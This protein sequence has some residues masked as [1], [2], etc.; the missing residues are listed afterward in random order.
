[1][2]RTMAVLITLFVGVASALAITP[3]TTVVASSLPPSEVDALIDLFNSTNGHQWTENRNWLKGDPCKDNW[4]G[5]VCEGGHVT[6]L[7]LAM[8]GLS[9]RLSESIGESLFAHLQNPGANHQ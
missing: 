4:H 3:T 2:L 8:N 1:M 6:R 5:V 9:G 7:N